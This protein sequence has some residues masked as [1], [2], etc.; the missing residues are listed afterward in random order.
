MIL[1][2]ISKS[3][4]K[5]KVLDDI[6][7]EIS[8]GSVTSFIGANGAGK[9][10]LLGIMSRII[11]RDT[12]SV[13]IDGVDIK[14][15]G[16]ENLAKKISILTQTNNI[17]MKLTVQELVSFGRFPYSKNRLTLEDKKYVEKSI[18]YMGLSNLKNSY[19]DE[20]SGGQRQ[21]VF[22]AMKIAQDTEYIFFD[23]PIN[24]LDIYY[25]TNLMKIIRK[26]CNEL[27][28]TIVLVLHDIN[29]AAFYS[30]YICALKNGK[31]FINDITK[32]VINKQNLSEIFDVDFEIIEKDDKLLSVYF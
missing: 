28:K 4:G 17:N 10:T 15:I 9:S 14:N 32:N 22:I 20:L 25:S 7:I 23:E 11:E 3:Y 2:N 12:G 26:L 19:I 29:Y 24:N 1:K 8:K 31:I 5:V 21:R 18:E 30:D 13:L 27:N 6:N 16:I